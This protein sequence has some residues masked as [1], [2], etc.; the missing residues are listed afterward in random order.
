L[1]SFT[2][3]EL[4]R[5]VGLRR[6]KGLVSRL[7]NEPGGVHAVLFYGPQG[8]GKS[9]LVRALTAAWLDK[10][11]D[12]PIRALER[13]NNPDVLELRP[14]TTSDQILIKQIR[15]DDSPD[16]DDPIAVDRFLRSMPLMSAH[17][18][19]AIHD[20]HR[21]NHRAANA[22]LKS[23]E[24]PLPHAKFILTTPSVGSVLP[25][26]LSRCLAVMCELPDPEELALMGEFSH[27]EL[28]ISEGTPGRLQEILEFRDR[29]APLI[30]FAEIL[31]KRSKGEA[32]KVAEEFR[33]LAEN[34]EA[35]FP[36]KE[37]YVSAETLE[38]LAVLLTRNPEIPGTWTQSIIEA[39]RR[40]KQNGHEGIITDALFTEMLNE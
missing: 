28:A 13:G 34:L 38:R 7:A 20:A 10:G 21:M 8:A 16:K 29:Y 25:T 2:A 30:R 9:Q 36:G 15:E 14:T 22:L 39:H 17:K 40:L 26:I 31:P 37:R 19:V 33:E 18:V 3:S 6:A 4:D 24:E 5:L 35:A 27:A 1:N 11:T 23:L 32:L 12:K